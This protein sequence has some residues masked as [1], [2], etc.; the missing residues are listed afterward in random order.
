MALTFRTDYWEDPS[1][2]RAFQQFMVDSFNLDF[3]LWEENG[4]WDEAFIPFS[5]FER[6]RIVASVCIYSLPAVIA[7]QPARVAQLS[8]VATHPEWQRRGLN[9]KL[10]ASALDQVQDHDAVLLFSTDEAIPFYRAVG[11]RS[12]VEQLEY[13]DVDPVT[14][15]AGRRRLDP[16]NPG[17]LQRIYQYA[18][19]RT[20][21]SNRFSFGNARLLMFHCLYTLRDH[22]YEITDLNCLVLYRRTGSCLQVFDIVAERLPDWSQLYPYLAEPGD[23][24]IEFHFH[25]DKL[26]LGQT[27]LLPLT[28]NNPLVRD[29][30]PL[31]RPVFPYTCRA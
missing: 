1:A 24:R 11:F 6:E 17:D 8:S 27:E 5:Y 21:V 30:F 4:F 31:E 28:G 22:L 14:P 25:T 3:T 23:T 19:Q 15:R 2:R 10:T 12:I 7:G 18:R 20:T 26:R 29:P 9:R 16:A 13:S